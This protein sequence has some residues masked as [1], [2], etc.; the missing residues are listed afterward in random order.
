VTQTLEFEANAEQG[1]D[2]CDVG[3]VCDNARQL[4]FKAESAGFGE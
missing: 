1:F 4:M 2:D 3:V